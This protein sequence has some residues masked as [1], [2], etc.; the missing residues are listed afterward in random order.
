MEFWFS[1]LFGLQVRDG[2][3]SIS[4]KGCFEAL[5]IENFPNIPGCSGC[6]PI[7]SDRVA[8][9]W[10]RSFHTEATG[11][12]G[13]FQDFGSLLLTLS[14]GPGGLHGDLEDACV[15]GSIE[16]CGQPIA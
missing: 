15:D 7:E 11:D 9:G 6:G 5:V 16:A 3:L 1:R 10:L 4:P 2:F 13:I 8:F 12:T 14:L